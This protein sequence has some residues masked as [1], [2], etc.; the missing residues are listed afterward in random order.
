MCC[1]PCSTG[2]LKAIDQ[3]EYQVTG[4]W[5]NPNIH[6]YMEYKNRLDSLKTFTAERKIDLVI[7]D[8]YGLKKF[9]KMLDN[10]FDNR[11][12]KCYY[13]R[14]YKTALKAKELGFDSFSTTLLVSPYQKHEHIKELGIKIQ[15]EIGIKF[16][17]FDPRPYFREGNKEARDNS[18]YMQKYCGCIFSEEERY[19]KK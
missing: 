1:A 19:L 4:Y 5:Y 6:P 16:I 14:L 15:N 12:S 3:E 10:D 7:D 11:C 2:T 13:E 9:I 17:Y 8:E 18:I